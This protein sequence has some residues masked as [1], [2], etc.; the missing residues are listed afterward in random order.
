[1]AY[2]RAY[3]TNYNWYRIMLPGLCIGRKKL[4]MLPHLWKNFTGYLCDSRLNSRSTWWRTKPRTIW[5]LGISVTWL[6][7][8]TGLNLT[9]LCESSKQNWLDEKSSKHKRSGDR[10]YSVCGPKLWNLVPL[11][12][13]ELF[14]KELKTNLFKKSFT[15][16]DKQVKQLWYF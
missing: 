5:P 2:L 15:L 4:I 14:K 13:V 12:S 16:S 1:M 6:N 11:S 3:W 8:T 10:A 9:W 7:H